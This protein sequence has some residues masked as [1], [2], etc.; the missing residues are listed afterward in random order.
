MLQLLIDQDFDHDILRG[1]SRRVLN[2]DVIT[3]HQV[4]LSNASDLELLEY[5]AS[6]NRLLL[7]HDLKTMPEHAATRLAEN[8]PMTGIIVVPRSLTINQ[9]IDELEIIAL[10]SE[11]AEWHKRICILPL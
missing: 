4:G 11:T 9:A 8:Q 5:A 2:L 6:E 1:L 3:A 7:T 10:C